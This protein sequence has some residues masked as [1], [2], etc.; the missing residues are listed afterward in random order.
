MSKTRRVVGV[1]GYRVEKTHKKPYVTMLCYTCKKKLDK[2]PAVISCE[3]LPIP[4]YA[5]VCAGCGAMTNE[6]YGELKRIVRFAQFNYPVTE[7]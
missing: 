3:Q 1:Y 4:S 7:R 6:A 2:D 5:Q